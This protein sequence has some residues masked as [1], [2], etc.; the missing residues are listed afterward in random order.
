MKLLESLIHSAAERLSAPPLPKFGFQI[1]WARSY[2]SLFEE[3]FTISD[4]NSVLNTAVES[5]RVLLCG[6]GGAAKSVI[7][8][9]LALTSV[10]AGFLPIKI[11]LKLWSGH[12]V[13]RWG[14]P[15][16]EYIDRFA[17]LIEC[18]SIG[19]TLQL[20]AELPLGRIKIFFV[21]G[22]NELQSGIGEQILQVLDI[23]V[24]E[25][26]GTRIIVSDR[27]VRR[28]L[29]APHR[30]RLATVLPLS[31]DEIHKQVASKPELS[32]QYETASPEERKL[33]SSPFF[34]NAFLNS[35]LRGDNKSSSFSSFF[36]TVPISAQELN[37][38][39]KAAFELYKKHSSRTFPVTDLERQISPELSV[40]L[41]EAGVL[42]LAG[43]SA[44]FTHH[45]AHDY[46]AATFLRT[47]PNKWNQSNFDVI[48]FY[49]SSFDSLAM[50]LE[51][52]E[53][54]EVAERLVRALFDWN[55]Y[56]AG[57][58]LAEEN[59]EGILGPEILVVVF[60]MM[61]ER[62]FDLIDATARRSADALRLS[63]ENIAKRFM[64]AASLADLFRE[65]RS[66]DSAQEWFLEWKSVFTIGPT[67]KIENSRVRLLTSPDSVLG[68]TM[69]NVL[70]RV[71]V[72]ASQIQLVGKL[73]GHQT[74][75]VRWRAV[76]VLGAF[77]SSL[78]LRILVKVLE[79][80]KHTWVRFGA[81]RSLVEMAAL[82]PSALRKRVFRLMSSRLGVI[83]AD[84]R[85]R[86]E[87][88]S[89]LLI[90]KIKRRDE[91]VGYVSLILRELYEDDSEPG[92]RE[93]FERIVRK[94][95][96]T[97]A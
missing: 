14:K 6:R 61:A 2:D 44:Y 27:L 66:V 11:D 49:G 75:V 63:S 80:D 89:V 50:M 4:E 81:V 45:L 24:T 96:E 76:H 77:P 22:L 85:S 65:V 46:L 35:G 13:D 60:A 38:L 28:D 56:A 67:G 32:Q 43:E 31:D 82:G 53:G 62:K 79:R 9:R 71:H 7:L 26:A 84:E 91:W 30:W 5:G 72:T 10:D 47:A 40:R 68:W 97:Y 18:A 59:R 57:Y 95:N 94:F 3:K 34:L 8:N 39:G 64:N 37:T 74:P 33:W 19:L 86:K 92:A 51:Q 1:G 54:P 12:D 78:N 23:A 16:A 21:D 88:E 70:K 93:R 73:T 48:S 55:P 42:K 41:Q 29:R 52:I 69:S 87:L 20:F 58:C 83:A 36:A 25:Y 17:Q 15:H 90:S